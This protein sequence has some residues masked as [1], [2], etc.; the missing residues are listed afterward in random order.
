MT[1][2]GLS[3]TQ[4]TL[5]MPTEKSEL[6]G[7]RGSPG[8]LPREWSMQEPC[9]SLSTIVYATPHF[10]NSPIH[11]LRG[12]KEI[13]SPK[14]NFKKYLYLLKYARGAGDE[15]QLVEC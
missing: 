9:R 3:V 4:L 7:G 15:A 13:S 6:A 14:A 2:F 5:V 1:H 10:R 8:T 11:R 12:C